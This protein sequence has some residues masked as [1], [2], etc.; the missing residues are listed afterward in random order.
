MATTPGGE[1]TKLFRSLIGAQDDFGGCSCQLATSGIIFCRLLVFI[2]LFSVCGFQ[3]E[4]VGGRD[5]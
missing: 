3:F 2:Y 4:G 5:G 1:N